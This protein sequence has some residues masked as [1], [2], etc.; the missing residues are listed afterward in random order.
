[1]LLLIS[2][3][4]IH[5]A[6]AAGQ[7]AAAVFPLAPPSSAARR[8]LTL[9]LD[10]TDPRTDPMLVSRWHIDGL[11]SVDANQGPPGSPPPLPASPLALAWPALRLFPEPLQAVAARYPCPPPAQPWLGSGLALGGVGLL[12]ISGG[13]LLENRMLATDSEP[14]A[15]RLYRAAVGVSFT[16]LAVSLGGAGL[17]V[18]A[19][20]QACREAEGGR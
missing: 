5:A 2:I 4:V 18:G 3:L 8:A 9:G 1:M 7:G 10:P 14:R 16:G 20:A 17:V 11:P 6:G 13:E 15:R 19:G 12:I